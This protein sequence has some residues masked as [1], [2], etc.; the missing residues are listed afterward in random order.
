MVLLRD[1]LFASV[2]ANLLPSM[3]VGARTLCMVVLCWDLMMKCTIDATIL[4]WLC[5]VDGRLMWLF[6]RY[7]LLR[8]SVN[9]CMPCGVF[10]VLAIASLNNMKF[11]VEYFWN[12]INVG[13]LHVVDWVIYT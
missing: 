3:H 9:M 12:P 5:W 7:I 8:L 2:S 6:K 11:G 1:P 4:G 10:W 13:R